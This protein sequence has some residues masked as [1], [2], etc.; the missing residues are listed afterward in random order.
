LF[1]SGHW[2]PINLQEERFTHSILS[3]RK[4]GGGRELPNI[5]VRLF[6]RKPQGVE[7]GDPAFLKA[8][9]QSWKRGEKKGK[10]GKDI[11]KVEVRWG[12]RKAGAVC[13]MELR[14]G[15]RKKRRSRGDRVTP[16]FSTKAQRKQLQPLQLHL[17]RQGNGR[18]QERPTLGGKEEIRG[19]KFRNVPKKG[20]KGHGQFFPYPAKKEVQGKYLHTLKE[21]RKGK[22]KITQPS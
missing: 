8:S 12:R 20:K 19:A 2:A 15:G 11:L 17:I 18:K 10:E 6:S 14:G 22:K 1:L 16:R 21:S 4:G 13:T 5:G 3:L 9:C 7:K